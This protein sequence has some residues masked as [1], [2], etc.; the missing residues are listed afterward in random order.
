MFSESNRKKAAQSM[1]QAEREAKPY[2]EL[3]QGVTPQHE[4]STM[5]ANIGR[6]QPARP[7]QLRG[8]ALPTKM[9]QLPQSCALPSAVDV[10]GKSRC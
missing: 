3:T 6:P 4:D 10:C 7:C 9:R 1:L 5:T 8:T 2:R